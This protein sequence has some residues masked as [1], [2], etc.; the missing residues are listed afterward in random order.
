MG[1]ETAPSKYTP[2][3]AFGKTGMP[4][5]R[6]DDIWKCIRWSE[7]PST[8]PDGMTSEQYR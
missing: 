7:Q 1:D 6:F 3:P 2:A 5:K 8:R 4:R